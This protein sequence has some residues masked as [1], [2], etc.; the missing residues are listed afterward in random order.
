MQLHIGDGLCRCIDYIDLTDDIYS[1]ECSLA[2][3]TLQCESVAT[4]LK[5]T[6]CSF[7]S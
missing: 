2:C 4:N 7:M 6:E 1:S 5:G 3:G